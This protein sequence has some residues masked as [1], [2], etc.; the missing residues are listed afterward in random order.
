VADQTDTFTGAYSETYPVE[1]ANGAEALFG[2]VHGNDGIV[3]RF[4][5]HGTD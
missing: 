5:A 1:C 4:T 3:L 2:A